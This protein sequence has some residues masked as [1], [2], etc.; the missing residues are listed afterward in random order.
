MKEDALRIAAGIPE[1][2]ARINVLRE[3]VQACILR[4]LHES[5][6]FQ[7][8]SFVGGTCLRF[9]YNLPRFSEDLD[10][11]L[12]REPPNPRETVANWFTKVRRDLKFLGFEAEVSLNTEKTVYTAWIRIPQLMAEAGL[13]N[14]PEQKLLDQRSWQALVLDAAKRSDL[15]TIRR[16]VT[17]FLE[18]PEEAAL[19]TRESIQ[20]LLL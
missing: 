10:F 3:Y 13:S 11:S 20:A 18:R 17:P 8:L 5:E 1:P 9:V 6:A 15:E 2:T 4:S 12:E 7:V 16:D 14:M 19:L